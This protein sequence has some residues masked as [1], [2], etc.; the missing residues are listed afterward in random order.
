MTAIWNADIALDENIAREVLQSQFPALEVHA[1]TAFQSG[2]DNW[3]FLVNHS[4]LFRFPRRHIAVPFVER[5]T[6]LLPMLEQRLPVPI[7]SIRFRGKPS[8]LYPYPFHGYPLLPGRRV[9]ELE[10]SEA[11]RAQATLPWARFLRAL[12]S[13]PLSEAISGGICKEDEIGR[14]DVRRRMPKLLER[15]EQSHTL[16]LIDSGTVARI[17]EHAGHWATLAD[18]A[19]RHAPLTVVHGDLNFTNFLVS[20]KGELRAVVDWGDAHVG[21][22]ALDLTIAYSFLPSYAVDTFFEAYGTV[23]Q[24]T[25]DLARF[26]AVYAALMIIVYACDTGR[27]KQLQEAQ[28]S[29]Q[30]ALSVP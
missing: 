19:A 11:D 25:R 13:T 2:W 30:R 21:H 9:H 15:A 5:E 29:L 6:R 14:M 16:G 24:S 12:H 8:A 10:L 26:R 23:S 22:P 27:A 18:V 1:I 17:D 3:L 28:S 20:S 7:P 4:I